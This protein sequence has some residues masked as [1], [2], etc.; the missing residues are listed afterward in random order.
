MR[1]RF[2]NS[3]GASPV[4]LTRDLSVWKRDGMCLLQARGEYF[5]QIWSFYELRF[6]T[7]EPERN[8]QMNSTD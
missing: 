6:W 8:R 1:R 7:Y 5:D 3:V 2:E 4:A